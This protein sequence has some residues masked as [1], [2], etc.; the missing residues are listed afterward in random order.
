MSDEVT[1]VLEFAK[2][3][4]LLALYPS[5]LLIIHNWKINRKIVDQNTQNIEKYWLYKLPSFHQDSFPFVIT[6]GSETFNLI[7][8]KKGRMQR[9]IIASGKTLYAQQAGLIINDSRPPSN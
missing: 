4:M 1:Q 2:N 9:L 6:S 7:D 3:R 8:V 5:D